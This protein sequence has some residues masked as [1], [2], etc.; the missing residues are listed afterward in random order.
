MTLTTAGRVAG[1]PADLELTPRRSD[2]I[3][4]VVATTDGAL[5]L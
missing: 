4:A 1:E 2:L 3:T 5:N